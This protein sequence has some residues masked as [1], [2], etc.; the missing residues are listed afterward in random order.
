MTA[1]FRDHMIM[2]SKDVGRSVDYLDSRSDIAKGRIGYIGL[3][4]GAALAPVFLALEPRLK[5]GV[6]YMGG[7]YQQPSLP[8][9]DSVNFAPRVTVPVL[10]L[11]GRFDSFFPTASSQEPLF[12][13]LGTPAEH[14]HRVLYDASHNIP[15]TEMM[16]E[17]V[18]WME[19]YWGL[20]TPR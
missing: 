10:M 12:K 16:K 18:A 6:I 14:K 7:F 9:A 13:L 15:R 8:E 5:L 2:W 1:G 3:S 4:S 17:V 19:K 20:P 11:S